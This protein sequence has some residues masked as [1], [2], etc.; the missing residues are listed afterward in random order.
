MYILYTLIYN[1]IMQCAAQRCLWGFDV[2]VCALCKKINVHRRT[3]RY[4]NDD[5]YYY[6]PPIGR[7]RYAY[8]I[9]I[10]YLSVYRYV[11]IIIIYL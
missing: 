5:D 7:D 6:T 1:I 3:H 2:C 4:D 8:I 9:I 10:L 11:I